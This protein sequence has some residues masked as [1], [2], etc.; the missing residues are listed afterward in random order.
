M[1]TLP[2]VVVVGALVFVYRKYNPLN[3]PNVRLHNFQR[4]FRAGVGFLIF[5]AMM[6][7]GYTAPTSLAHLL[8]SIQTN[9]LEQMAQRQDARQA[10]ELRHVTR[11]I[12]VLGGPDNYL[13][14]EKRRRAL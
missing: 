5:I 14:Y 4:R 3:Q 8:A 2:L 13:A 7:I 6:L 1:H 12:E 9:Q 10:S 11:M